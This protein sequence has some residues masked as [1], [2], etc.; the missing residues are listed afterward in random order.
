MERGGEAGVRR[1][2]F[3]HALK[4][5]VPPPATV[6]LQHHSY[7]PHLLSRSF[8]CFAGKQPELPPATRPSSRA[9]RLPSCDPEDT[10]MMELTTGPTTMASIVV[11]NRYGLTF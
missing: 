11:T 3:H 7:A 6:A 5:S 8:A 4:L 1:P 9:P 10:P 2:A